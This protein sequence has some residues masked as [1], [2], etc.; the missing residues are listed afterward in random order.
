MV[1]EI[2]LPAVSFA[3]QKKPEWTEVNKHFSF[4]DG[5]GGEIS[6][7]HP[8]LLLWDSETIRMLEGRGEKIFPGGKLVGDCVL[9]MT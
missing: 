2:I 5:A 9:P 7:P 3:Q 6:L 4:S 8:F 1:H